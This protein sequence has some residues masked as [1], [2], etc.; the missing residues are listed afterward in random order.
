[1]PFHGFARTSE[2]V[3]ESIKQD[4]VTFYLRDNEHTFAIYPFKF[5][6]RITYRIDADSI[7]IE[8]EIKNKGAVT[9]PYALGRHDSFVLDKPLENYKL[10]F[11]LDEDFLSQQCDKSGRLINL[12]YDFG[13][14]R[15]LVIPSD[16]LIDGQTLIFGNINSDYL[17]LK[18]VDNR[19]IARFFFGKVSNVLFW[20][21]NFSQ[22]ICIDPWTALPDSADEYNIDCLKKTRLS[23]LKADG[24]EVIRFGIKMF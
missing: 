14:G 1:M 9:M 2:F 8:N 13:S 3:C 11:P 5:E 22:M 6:L 4:E 18:T 21:P 20:R 23:L 12:Y 10:C 19:P 17:T 15:E 24:T 16:Y 7:I